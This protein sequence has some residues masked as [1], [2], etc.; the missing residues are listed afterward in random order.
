MSATPPSFVIICSRTHSFGPN[1]SPVWG[2]DT[3]KL[4]LMIGKATS[5]LSAPADAPFTWRG[6]RQ[7]PSVE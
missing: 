3:A 4:M 2:S 7:A 6:S 1:L 5:H